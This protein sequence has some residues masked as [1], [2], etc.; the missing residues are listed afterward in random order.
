MSVTHSHSMPSLHTDSTHAISFHDSPMKI[1]LSSQM[2]SSSLGLGK[3]CQSDS[4]GYQEI[5]SA[6]DFFCIF[7]PACICDASSL[8]KKTT[9]PISKT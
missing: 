2:I 8:A 5:F 9:I 1:N 6:N 7:L 4:E 3:E